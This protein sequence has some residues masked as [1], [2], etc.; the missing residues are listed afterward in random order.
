MRTYRRRLSRDPALPVER[1]RREACTCL[2]FIASLV[3]SRKHDS[4]TA[5]LDRQHRGPHEPV[6]ISRD[7][8]SRARRISRTVSCWDSGFARASVLLRDARLSI[9]EVARLWFGF[10]TPYHFTRAFRRMTGL[11][12]NE[13][14]K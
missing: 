8:S 3:S 4:E 13:Y 9:G 5:I 10:G 11:A 14:R 7:S 12:P 1:V 6:T 2:G